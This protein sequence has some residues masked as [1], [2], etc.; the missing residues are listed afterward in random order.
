MYISDCVIRFV[1]LLLLAQLLAAVFFFRLF[2]DKGVA[3]TKL[4]L[5][6]PRHS[7]VTSL[8]LSKWNSGSLKCMAWSSSC[9]IKYRSKEM[10]KTMSSSSGLFS[11]VLLIHM[12][13]IWLHRLKKYHQGDNEYKCIK[14]PLRKNMTNIK[15]YKKHC[16]LRKVRRIF[17]FIYFC[18][19]VC[20]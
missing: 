15:D 5:S 6:S 14:L 12:K 18:M 7:C 2:L 3:L 17:S 1:W 10:N 8:K 16:T 11:F 9:L 4:F 13:A 20:E 19:C